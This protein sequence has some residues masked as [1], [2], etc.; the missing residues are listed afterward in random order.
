M[1]SVLEL[2]LPEFARTDTLRH[3]L[4][5]PQP[6]DLRWR[7]RRIARRHAS[8]RTKRRGMPDGWYTHKAKYIPLQDI[9]TV[10][11]LYPLP[12]NQFFDWCCSIEPCAFGNR[13][14]WNARLG[15]SPC[16]FQ[17]HPQLGTGSECLTNLPSSINRDGPFPRNELIHSLNRTPDD[18]GKVG[19]GPT[20]SVKLFLNELAG[21]E[22]FSCKDVGHAIPLSV[23]DSLRSKS[24][25]WCSSEFPSQSQRSVSIDR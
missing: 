3:F 12:P 17:V 6:R 15:K 21:G 8:C 18:R 24:P 14:I 23:S 2:T 5:L 25:R 20:P 13:T 9:I 19:L 1:D 4:C 10:V 7:P 11:A 22:H 16:G